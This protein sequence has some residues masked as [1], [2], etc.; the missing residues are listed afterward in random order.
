MRSG[1]LRSSKSMSCSA[2]WACVAVCVSFI[3]WVF[4]LCLRLLLLFHIRNLYHR[5]VL[6]PC[7]FSVLKKKDVK[8]QRRSLDECSFISD[9]RTADPS[10]I[11]NMSP[12]ILNIITRRV[13]KFMG[14]NELKGLNVCFCL[15]TWMPRA[16]SSE[17]QG[18]NSSTLRYPPAAPS[19]CVSWSFLLPE[20]PLRL[21][22][23]WK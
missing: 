20:F 4:S 16:G 2:G 3:C 18:E 11:S 15:C 5:A 7:L 14:L 19:S 13:N 9:L 17:N 12:L 1:S 8:F 10:F 6:K 22:G 21:T 23:A